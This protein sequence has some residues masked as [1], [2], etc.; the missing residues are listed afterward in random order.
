MKYSNF[1]VDNLNFTR[2]IYRI[3]ID[4]RQKQFFYLSPTKW[5]N[6]PALAYFYIDLI[7]RQ[8]DY[9]LMFIIMLI[10]LVFSL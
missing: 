9:K 5:N 8:D 7:L 3:N 2:G 10:I 4:S 1:T 6:V